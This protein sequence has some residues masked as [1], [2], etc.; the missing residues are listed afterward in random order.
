MMTFR[1]VLAVPSPF[2][3]LRDKYDSDPVYLPASEDSEH[4]R[5]SSRIPV[6]GHSQTISKVQSEFIIESRTL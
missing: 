2:W 5:G 3:T 1:N 6:F 4:L